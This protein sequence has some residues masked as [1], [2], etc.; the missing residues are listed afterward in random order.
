MCWTYFALSTYEVYLEW[1]NPSQT[2]WY[3]AKQR[4]G[5]DIHGGRLIVQ[6]SRKI[7][8]GIDYEELTESIDG[9]DRTPP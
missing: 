1:T 6:I 8:K 9:G 4:S 5:W 7:K 2:A 3:Y